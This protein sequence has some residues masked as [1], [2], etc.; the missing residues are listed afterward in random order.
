MDNKVEGTLTNLLWSNIVATNYVSTNNHDLNG[1]PYLIP[2]PGKRVMD[3]SLR[4]Q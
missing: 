4:S 2:L 3:E 1:Q